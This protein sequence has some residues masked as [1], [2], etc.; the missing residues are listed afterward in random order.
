MIQ[1]EVKLEDFLGYHIEVYKLCIQEI[2]DILC[3]IGQVVE[4]KKNLKR[5]GFKMFI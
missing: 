2:L 4:W 3:M 5:E 1:E